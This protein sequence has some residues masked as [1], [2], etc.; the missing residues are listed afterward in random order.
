M[1]ESLKG[2]LVETGTFRIDRDRALEKLRDFQLSNPWD[3][4]LDIARA[5]SLSQPEYIKV[6]NIGNSLRMSFDGEPLSKKTLRDPFA[7]LF[8]D[9]SESTE[10]E[11]CLAFGI[12]AAL[13]RKPVSITLESGHGANR[14]LLQLTSLNSLKR[15]DPGDDEGETIVTITW[16]GPLKASRKVNH[17]RTDLGFIDAN[18]VAN[19]KGLGRRPLS[20]GRGYRDIILKR[21]DGVAAVGRR[22]GNATAGLVQHYIHGVRAGD[23]VPY[24]DSRFSH[25][26]VFIEDDEYKLNIAR[27]NV[28]RS[29]KAR[30]TIKS[31]F[32]EADKRFPF[33]QK[34]RWWV[35]MILCSPTLFGLYYAVMP[36]IPRG[37]PVFSF[38]EVFLFAMLNA[39]ILGV[40]KDFYVKR[41]RKIL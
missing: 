20:H 39:V 35:F 18:L 14:V 36:R 1:D 21:K 28:E 10:R 33:H 6:D 19:G 11:R 12:L 2:E 9:E 15:I 26:S 31:V 40:T 5:A 27:G 30:H 22:G 8:E 23:P 25:L 29:G 17:I 7:V 41:V 13:R 16:D 37:A 3:F 32:E 24:G 4:H 34:T 38:A